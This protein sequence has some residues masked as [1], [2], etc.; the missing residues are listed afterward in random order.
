MSRRSVRRTFRRLPKV[1]PATALRPVAYAVLLACCDAALGNPTGEQTVRGD[2]GYSRVPL[3]KLHAEPA[4]RALREAGVE[5][6]TKARV[7]AVRPGVAV[8]SDA[9]TFEA[10]AGSLSQE[11]ATC[12][13]AVQPVVS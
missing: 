4:E 8:E 9:G 5:L 10:E 2:V 6:H 12:A 1:A 7:Q 13:T 11:L 3:S